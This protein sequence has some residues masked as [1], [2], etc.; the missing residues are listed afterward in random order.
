MSLYLT[1]NNTSSFYFKLSVTRN[2]ILSMLDENTYWKAKQ[3]E[4]NLK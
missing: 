3:N 1:G 4:V 2:S